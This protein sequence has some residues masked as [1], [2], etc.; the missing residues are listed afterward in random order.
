MNS[1]REKRNLLNDDVVLLNKSTGNFLVKVRDIIAIE[2]TDKVLM[3]VYGTSFEKMQVRGT[4]VRI[5]ERLPDNFIYTNRQCLINRHT[6][7][8]F[9]AK[10]KEVILS[11]QSGELSFT[12]SRENTKKIADLFKAK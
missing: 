1:Y 6:I 4:L 10:T 11:S 2:K 8:S 3:A 12:C 5:K 7:K 9:D